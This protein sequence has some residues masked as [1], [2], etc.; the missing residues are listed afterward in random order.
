MGFK[1]HNEASSELVAASLR[2]KIIAFNSPFFGLNKRTPIAVTFT[3]QVNEMQGG[4]SGIAFGYWFML[5]WLWVDESLR[6]QKIGEQLLARIEQQAIEQGCRYVLL[7]TLD[8]QA[9]PFYE[10]CGYKVVHQL[11]QYPTTGIKYYME[12]ELGLNPV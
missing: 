2:E 7:D 12:K 9:K 5:N 6:G 11:H 4:A 8:F 1:I 10:K 3:R